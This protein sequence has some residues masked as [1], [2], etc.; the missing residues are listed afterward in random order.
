MSISQVPGV[1]RS[2][3]RECLRCVPGDAHESPH[4]SSTEHS[5]ATLLMRSAVHLAIALIAAALAVL[6]DSLAAQDSPSDRVRDAL[7]R[8]VAEVVL[9]RMA[10]ARASGLPDLPMANLALEGVA[11]GR[12][13]DEVLA[14]VESLA[15][16]MG[17]ARDLLRSAERAPESG[18][19]EAAA[20]VM[21]MGVDGASI[22]EL[23]RQAPQGRS[24]MVPIFALGSLSARGLPSDQALGAVAERLAAR[25]VDGELFGSTA[26]S[27]AARGLGVGPGQ[28]GPAGAGGLAG[29]GAHVAGINVPAGPP[30]HAGGPPPGRPGRPDTPGAPGR[31]R[32][33]G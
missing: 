29:A 2:D 8:P 26:G 30:P 5:P 25:A 16:R 20:A 19:I 31:G 17:Q 18:E 28:V 10:S 4:P 9:Q 6:P 22:A 21:R 33:G 32:P 3:D 23:A 7:P 11:K 27:A 12:S 1:T 14:A 24:L 15:D 13:A